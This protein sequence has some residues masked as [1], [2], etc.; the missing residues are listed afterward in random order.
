MP[1][2]LELIELRKSFEEIRAVDGLSIA[3]EEGEILGLLGPNGAGKTTCINMVCGLLKQDSGRILF[4]GIDM[5]GQ[6]EELKR[7][8][9]L[10]PQALVVWE[11]LTVRGKPRI[12]GAAVRPRPRPNR[13]EGREPPRGT[14]PSAQGG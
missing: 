5:A 2:A 3:V 1:I 6:G 12:P 11:R 4:K 14:R 8:V 13:I 7:R 9:G 10:C